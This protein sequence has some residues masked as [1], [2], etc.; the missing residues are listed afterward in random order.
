MSQEKFD[1]F[2]KRYGKKPD[3]NSPEWHCWF[4]G[5]DDAVR[6]CNYE[7]HKAFAKTTPIPN[8]EGGREDT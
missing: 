7:M 6:W 3:L 1:A 5:W 2:V 4:H 8:I